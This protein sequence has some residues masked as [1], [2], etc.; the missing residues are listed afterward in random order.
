[1]N[2]YL[3]YFTGRLSGSIGICYKIE[4]DCFGDSEEKAISNLYDR[5]EHI[6]DLTIIKLK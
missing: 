5:F 6:T 1:M 4:T 2:K 3:V